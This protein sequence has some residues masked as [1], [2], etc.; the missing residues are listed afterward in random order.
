MTNTWNSYD[1]DIEKKLVTSYVIRGIPVYETFYLKVQVFRNSLSL[2]TSAL[3][4]SSV[5]LNTQDLHYLLALTKRKG[6]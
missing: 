5:K 2:S 1:I 4:C 6:T 3:R